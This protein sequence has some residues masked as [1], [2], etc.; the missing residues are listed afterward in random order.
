MELTISDLLTVSGLAVVITIVVQL[1]KGWIE[2][3]FVP[4]FAV[5]VGVCLAVIASVVLQQYGPEAVAQA[6]LT[7]L[8]GGASAIGIYKLQQPTG[9]LKGKE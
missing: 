1:A 2:E 7:G 9:V 6:V 4:L 8:L 3:R 5:A